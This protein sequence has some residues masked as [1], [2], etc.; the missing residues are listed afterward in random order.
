MHLLPSLKLTCVTAEHIFHAEKL[1]ILHQYV[2]IVK[3]NRKMH[4]NIIKI[5][6]KVKFYRILPPLKKTSN[7]HRKEASKTPKSKKTQKNSNFDRK[8]IENEELQTQNKSWKKSAN[9]KFL[10]H[11]SQKVK[12][13][14]S[15]YF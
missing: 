13:K 9:A 1:F 14:I 12:T 7:G 10:A 5:G 2:Q 15:N 11:Q 6:K 3:I 8:T 4:K